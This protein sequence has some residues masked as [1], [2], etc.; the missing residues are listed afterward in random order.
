[1]SGRKAG[2]E[3]QRH[4]SWAG[5]KGCLTSVRSVQEP[6]EPMTL[7]AVDEEVQELLGVSEMQ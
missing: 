2:H 5:I 1:M 7:R 6:V 3:E 4:R